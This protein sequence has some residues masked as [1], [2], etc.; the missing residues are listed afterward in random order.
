MSLYYCPMPRITLRVFRIERRAD[1]V[2]TSFQCCFSVEYTCSV[3]KCLLEIISP[4]MSFENF[5]A[6]IL[7][8]KLIITFI[9]NLF[10]S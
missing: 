4:L 6:L 2:K 3:C 1:Y 8:N 9:N 7:L 10:S 5:M